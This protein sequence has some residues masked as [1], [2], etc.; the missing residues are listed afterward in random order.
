MSK[1][2]EERKTG[3]RTG[4]DDRV[5][6]IGWGLGAAALLAVAA[7]AVLAWYVLA[8]PDGS[9]EPTGGVVSTAP[10]SPEALPTAARE[11]GAWF[12]PDGEPV[13]GGPNAPVTIIEYSDYQCPNCAQFALDVL[14]WLRLGWM[15]DGMVRVV[16][17]DFAIRGGESV[18]AARAAHCAGEQG[19]YWTYHDALFASQSGENSG[20]FSADNLVRLA[21]SVGV[22]GAQL[23]ACLD[24][25]RYAD[26]V[27]AST[28]EA[29]DQGFE[30]TPT[31]LVNG[32]RTQGAIE[33]EKWE[34]LFSLFM[35]ENATATAAAGTTD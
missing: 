24:A 25:G 2:G 10:Q 20:A 23:A 29:Y 30:G 21:D 35:A 15:G 33:T 31:Y 22:D 12:T 17:R 9:V 27:A 19:L 34:E 5:I 6:E 26:R 4:G 28:Q 11:P 14:P 3:G 18:L 7:V 8:R 13:L 32:R 16:F 1:R